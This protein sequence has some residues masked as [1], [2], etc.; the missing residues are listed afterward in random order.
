MIHLKRPFLLAFQ[1]ESALAVIT[2]RL[3][4]RCDYTNVWLSHGATCGNCRLSTPQ[5]CINSPHHDRFNDIP[6]CAKCDATVYRPAEDSATN[7]CPFSRTN[8]NKSTCYKLEFRICRSN[9]FVII[10]IVY[11]SLAFV[12]F[13]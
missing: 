12:D 10:G 1:S 2:Y 7:A 11:T 5:L 9:V 4:R 6:A 3:V 13:Y 8:D